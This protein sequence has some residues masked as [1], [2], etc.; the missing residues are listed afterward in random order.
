VLDVTCVAAKR[1]LPEIIEK[2]G[3]KIG[4]LHLY[5]MYFRINALLAI[6]GQAI[7]KYSST[8]KKIYFLQLF[9][10]IYLTIV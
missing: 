8:P 4:I 5:K 2:M 3:F 10:K 1:L 6:F 7:L 9:S